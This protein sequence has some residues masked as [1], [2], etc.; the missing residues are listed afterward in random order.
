MGDLET[1][2][3]LFYTPSACVEVRALG[4]SGGNKRWKGWA[5]GVVA[6]YFDDMQSFIDCVESLD[7]YGKA[8]AIYITLNPLNPDLL[9]RANNRLVGI[10]KNDPTAKDEDVLQRRWL[11]VDIDPV[12]PTGIS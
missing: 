6:G 11:L 3:K 4:I 12:R 5:G 7:D 2:W 1:T 8:E 10:G 9:A